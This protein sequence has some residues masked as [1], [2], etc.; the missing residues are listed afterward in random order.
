[1]LLLIL[2]RHRHELSGNCR[3]K[4]DPSLSEEVDDIE[5]G[6]LRLPAGGWFT[7]AEDGLASPAASTA[8][9]ASTLK[10]ATR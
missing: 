3:G 6:T 8:T 10:M 1:M 2:L 9:D 4:L 5:G 7:C